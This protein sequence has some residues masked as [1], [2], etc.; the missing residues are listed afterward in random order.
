[1]LVLR[2][3]A[4]VDALAFVIAAFVTLTEIERVGVVPVLYAVFGGVASVA[5]LL[6]LAEILDLGIGIATKVQTPSRPAEEGSN[7]PGVR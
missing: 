7:P 5:V 4:V 1:V 3:V 2:V 6:A